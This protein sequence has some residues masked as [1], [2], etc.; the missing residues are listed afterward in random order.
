MARFFVPLDVNYADDERLTTAGV[1]A[2]VLYVRALAFSARLETGG[3]IHRVQLPVIGLGL[4]R[5]TMQ[6]QRL[7]D[8]GL[9]HATDTGWII[10][11]RSR[12]SPQEQGEF[13]RRRHRVYCRRH[14]IFTRDDYRCQE[15]GATDR[16]EV[17]HITPIT[18]GGSDDPENLQTLCKS[19]NC[20]KGNRT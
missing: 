14:E 6:A 15:C 11:P 7:V 4:T 3:H 19:C 9:W 2:E 12:R 13:Q 8:A 10:T 20:R 18:K 17:D 1:H 16:L 5:P